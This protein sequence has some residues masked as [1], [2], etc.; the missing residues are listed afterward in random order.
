MMMLRG[1]LTM[2]VLDML[3]GRVLHVR[4]AKLKCSIDVM[5]AGV[6]KAYAWLMAKFC[7]GGTYMC[8]FDDC[9]DAFGC[10]R[11]A[12]GGSCFFRIRTGGRKIERSLAYDQTV[13]E[14][15]WMSEVAP[16]RV[17]R[18]NNHSSHEHRFAG[19]AVH[20][21]QFCIPALRGSA[22]STRQHE[23]H[24][25]SSHRCLVHT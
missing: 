1:Q 24:T 20:S 9:V 2:P 11:E 12:G 16:W 19:R 13:F 6:G 22:P 21:M 4:K 23:L 10:T 17:R 14:K 8:C 25:T 15:D 7:S 3:K 18:R 5:R